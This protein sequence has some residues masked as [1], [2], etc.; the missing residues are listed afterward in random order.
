[1]TLLNRSDLKNSYS[2][3]AI[4]GDNPK[5]TGTPDSTLF[6]R[7]EGYEVLYLINK[8]AD[9]HS[10]K[11]KASGLKIE[12]ML[13]DLPSSTRKQTDVITWIEQNWDNY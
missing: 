1:M 4:G 8:V 3:T 6:N 11:Q 13:K 7:G 12:S 5:I 9:K 2:W 10:F